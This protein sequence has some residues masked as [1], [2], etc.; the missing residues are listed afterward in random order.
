MYVSNNSSLSRKHVISPCHIIFNSIESF[1]IATEN[2]FIILELDCSFFEW[3]W[4]KKFFIE[5][6]NQVEIIKILLEL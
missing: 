2:L 5:E 6:Q 1:R 3:I 4:I